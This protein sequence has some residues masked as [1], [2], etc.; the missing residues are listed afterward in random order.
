MNAERLLTHYERIADHRRAGSRRRAGRFFGRSRPVA[1]HFTSLSR[2]FHPIALIPLL[3]CEPSMN[4]L[5][6]FRSSFRRT[7]WPCRE[8][9]A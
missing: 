5:R 3:S 9:R 6:N 4:T 8:Q 1:Q 7:T 2:D